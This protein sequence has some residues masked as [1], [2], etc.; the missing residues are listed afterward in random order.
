M[1]IN[2]AVLLLLLIDGCCIHC[3]DVMG[4]EI[5]DDEDTTD[6]GTNDG[7]LLDKKA[8]AKDEPLQPIDRR[9]IADEI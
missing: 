3:L 6:D 2:L 5:D 1:D 7:A 4:D 9:M 8:N